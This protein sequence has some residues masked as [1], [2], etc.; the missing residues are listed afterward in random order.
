MITKDAKKNAEMHI[1]T[2]AAIG[3]SMAKANRKKKAE[4][5]TVNGM[6]LF[7]DRFMM[8]CIRDYKKGKITKDCLRAI[9]ILV[10]N[11]I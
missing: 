11:M 2:K 4:R 10:R 6:E 1:S 5:S 3:S 7:T 9:C 8:Q